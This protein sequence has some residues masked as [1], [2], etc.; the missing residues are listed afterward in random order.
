MILHKI[1][2]GVDLKINNP[3]LI[4]KKWVSLNKKLKNGITNVFILGG[5]TI[6]LDE[7]SLI[8]KHKIPYQ[9]YPVKRKY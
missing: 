7:Y 9:Y 6:T 8:K 2:N 1:V 3:V 4:L 5:G